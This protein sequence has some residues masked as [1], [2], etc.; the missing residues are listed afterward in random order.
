[1]DDIV[2]TLQGLGLRRLQS[3]AAWIFLRTCLT[4]NCMSYVHRL[5]MEKKIKKIE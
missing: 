5:V 4:I 2:K 1:M 3:C